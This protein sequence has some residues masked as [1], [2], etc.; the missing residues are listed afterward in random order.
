MTW[1]DAGSGGDSSSVTSDLTN[2]S[3]IISNG[4]AFAAVKTDGS[5]VT[6]G[7][8]GSGGDSSAVQNDLLGGHSRHTYTITDNEIVPIITFSSASSSGL[9]SVASKDITVTLSEA[10][11]NTVSIDYALTGTATGSGTDYTLANG[12]L[13]IAAGQT[14]GTITITDIVDDSL[15]ESHETVTVTLSNPTNGFI[16]APAA[17]VGNN[18]AFAAIKANG[19][20]VTWVNLVVL[21]KLVQTVPRLIYQVILVRLLVLAV[22]SRL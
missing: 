17:I 2:V 18:S 22:H 4:S 14:S 11:N 9:E 20:V 21:E 15:V 6:W 5:V 10:S 8:A 13:T 1:G 19:S 3:S 7:N 16:Y 12:T